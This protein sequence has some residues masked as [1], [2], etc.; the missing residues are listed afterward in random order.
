MRLIYALAILVSL[1]LTACSTTT[2]YIVRHAE[3]VSEADTTNLTPAGYARAAALADQLGN[4][5]ID[6]IFTTPYRRTRQTAQP[7]AT[8]LGLSLIDYPAKPTDAIVNRVSQ[9]RGK[10]LLVVGHSNTILEIAK[11][12]GAQPT[13]TRIESGDF[14]N[15]FRVDVKRGLFG[16]SV[17]FSQTTYGQPTPP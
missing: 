9:I 1:G 17:S 8:R 3:K 16:K 11:G 2:V 15:L 14:D 7:L 5:S 13:M 4:A 10:Q 6:S 12:L